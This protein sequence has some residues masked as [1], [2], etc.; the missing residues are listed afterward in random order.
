MNE[1][2]PDQP[3]NSHPDVADAVKALQALISLVLRRTASASGTAAADALLSDITSGS[4]ELLFTIDMRQV[5][6]RICAL[7]RRA[8][9]EPVPLLNFEIALLQ[10]GSPAG[11]AGGL[12]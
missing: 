3:K 4:R 10:L 6:A 8:G 1:S 11:G 9:E 5:E 2:A 7:G 12:H